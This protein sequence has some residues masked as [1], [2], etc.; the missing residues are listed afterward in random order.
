VKTISVASVA[1][2]LVL[3]CGVAGSAAYVFGIE[4]ATVRIATHAWK[5][6]NWVTLHGAPTGAQFQ[7]TRV[8]AS[9]TETA[10][11]TATGTARS[12]GS[13]A[14]GYVV[15]GYSCPGGGSGCTPQPIP[16]DYPVC[17]VP[18]PSNGILCYATQVTVTCFCGERVPVR[19]RAPGSA[20]N[21]PANTLNGPNF[22]N[23]GVTLLVR[24]PAPIA[25]GSDGVAVRVVSQADISSAAAALTKQLGT[26]L[27]AALPQAASGQHVVPDGSATVTVSTSVAAGA[28][29]S[30]FQVTATGTLGGTT[31]RDA[32]LQPL[33]ARSLDGF[34]PARFRLRA[35]PSVSEYRIVDSDQQGNVTVSGKVEGELVSIFLV[36][37]LRVELRG[38]DLGMARTIVEA[39]APE[40]RVDIRT[41]PLG[42]P[43][44]PMNAARISIVVVD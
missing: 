37:S 33:I 19:A 16:P 13:R 8:K 36:D 11:G 5:L 43:W 21:V 7:T 35:P 12:A 3:V 28:R 31:F 26:D 24:Q 44:L 38:H 1:V 18:D 9:L 6:D 34:V 32:D 22:W 20:F 27:Q 41:T 42:L 40:S 10:T 30:T 39:A 23:Y 29:A 17:R 25:G 15:F 2:V 14:T 4:S